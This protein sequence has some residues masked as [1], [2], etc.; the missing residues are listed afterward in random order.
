MYIHMHM[1]VC[2]SV[3]VDHS[4]SVGDHDGAR[5]NSRIAFYWNIAAIVGGIVVGVISGIGVGIY[6][7]SYSYYPYNNY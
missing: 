7:G 5:R 6:F 2:V 3:Q 1:C 4:W